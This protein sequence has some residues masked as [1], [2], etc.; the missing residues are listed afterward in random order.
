M[1]VGAA[2]DTQLRFAA[3]SGS[4]S[5]SS[6]FHRHGAGLIGLALVLGAPTALARTPNIPHGQLYD[7]ARRELR[8]QG[9]LPVPVKH[10]K[11]SYS[12]MVS[13]WCEKYPELMYCAGTGVAACNFAFRQRGTSKYLVVSTAGEM[14]PRV[15]GWRAAGPADQQDIASPPN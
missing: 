7:D 10:A 9:Y 2:D 11:D 5:R 15:A 1:D 8:A 13:G 12:C 4:R 3:S 6:T 14:H